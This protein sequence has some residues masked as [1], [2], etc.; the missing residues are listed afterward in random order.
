[1]AV[2]SNGNVL[3]WAE[4]G[5]D[6]QRFELIPVDPP[7]RPEPRKSEVQPGDIGDIPRLTSYDTRL[8]EKTDPVLVGETIVPSVMINDSQYSDKL[9]Q[10]LSCPYYRLSR[11]QY[12]DRRTGRGAFLDHDGKTETTRTIEVTTGI[13]ETESKTIENTVGFKITVGLGSNFEGGA[14][15]SLGFEITN[16]L[17]TTYSTETTRM[18]ETKRSLTWQFQKGARTLKALWSLV[19]R[20]ELRRTSD[21]SEVTSWE[22]TLDD[23]QKEDAFQGK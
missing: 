14:T 21:N 6:D 12:W 3:R 1:M 2:G 5:Q 13:S 7:T 8:P 22:I 9:S 10:F 4:T 17:K 15:A 23:T 19:D 18:K 20:Y 16:E 11:Y